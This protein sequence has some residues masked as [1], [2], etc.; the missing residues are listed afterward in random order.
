MN[1]AKKIQTSPLKSRRYLLHHRLLLRRD[2]AVREIHGNGEMTGIL[3]DE[4]VVGTI[5]IVT[6]LLLL[7]LRLFVSVTT[8][9]DGLAIPLLLLFILFVTGVVDILLLIAVRLHFHH[10]SAHVEMTM[11][12]AVEALEV[13]SGTAIEDMVM[14]IK[15]GMSVRWGVD[16][17]I[18]MRGVMDDLQVARQV[19]IETGGLVGEDLRILLAQRTI[20]ER[21]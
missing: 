7:I 5:T 16:L 17:V 3:I 20:K 11:M 8:N 15:S 18:L 19:A 12:T 21:D 9:V 14:I 1:E 2:A 4:V 10:I 13:V 6:G